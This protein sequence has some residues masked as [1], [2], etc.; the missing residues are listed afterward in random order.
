MK[1]LLR[2]A[3]VTLLE[4]VSRYPRLKRW[5]TGVVYRIPAL[6]AGLRT[7]AR[8]AAYPEARLDVDPTQ[9]PEG[10]R[11]SFERMRTRSFR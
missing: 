11:R 7:A 2:H 6:D 3:T 4:A 5:L 10:S 9:L 8:R 1:G